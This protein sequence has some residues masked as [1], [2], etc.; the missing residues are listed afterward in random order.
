MTRSSCWLLLALLVS[1]LPSVLTS[2]P[3]SS[4]SLFLH[5]CNGAV[6]KP[7]KVSPPQANR[8]LAYHL[9]VPGE[10][11][12]LGADDRDAWSSIVRAEKQGKEGVKAFFEDTR[13]RTI[14]LLNGVDEAELR[15]ERPCIRIFFL[16]D[17]LTC[18]PSHL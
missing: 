15:G 11:L 17:Q 10:F 12:G 18:S 9:D 13:Q 7:A 16:I 14:V 8:L 2:S 4:A 5:P 6:T 1:I 3:S